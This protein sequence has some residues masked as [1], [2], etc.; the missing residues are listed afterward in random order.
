MTDIKALRSAKEMP[1]RAIP[2]PDPFVFPAGA[3][4]VERSVA[5]RDLPWQHDLGDPF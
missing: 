1:T 3:I 2:G 5:F 4:L